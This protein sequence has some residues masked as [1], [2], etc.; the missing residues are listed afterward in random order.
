MVRLP[1]SQLANVTHMGFSLSIKISVCV[2]RAPT[3]VRMSKNP[4]IYRNGW[5]VL[6]LIF[7]WGVL[8]GTLYQYDVLK[9]ART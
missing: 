5:S 8:G 7:V 6:G 2:H 3:S 9:M 4:H 1:Q